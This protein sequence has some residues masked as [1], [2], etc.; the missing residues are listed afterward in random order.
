MENCLKT[1]SDTMPNTTKDTNTQTLS[2]SKE[3]PSSKSDSYFED[4]YS[5]LEIFSLQE[6]KFWY[7]L[8]K[9]KGLL[10]FYTKYLS[11]KAGNV[12]MWFKIVASLYVREN[13]RGSL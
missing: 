10:N 12:K 5:W 3:L 7:L 11:E 1:L 4:P 6:E 8:Q 9:Q 2:S 13:L